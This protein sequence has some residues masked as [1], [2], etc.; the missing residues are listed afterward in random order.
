MNQDDVLGQLFTLRAKVQDLELELKESAEF[1]LVIGDSGSVE[2]H[3][4]SS[5]VTI[6][7]AD[8]DK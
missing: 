2:P 4:L 7:R 3:D 5:E 1:R 6:L 8:N